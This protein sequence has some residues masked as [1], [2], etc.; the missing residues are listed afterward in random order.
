M[1]QRIHFG[2]EWKKK[3]C[4]LPGDTLCEDYLRE[5]IKELSG[6]SVCLILTP[7]NIMSV[8]H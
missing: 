1:P 5:A 8:Y 3:G 4:V 2:A 7:L 6:Y